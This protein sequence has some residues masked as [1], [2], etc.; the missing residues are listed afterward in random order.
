MRCGAVGALAGL[1]HDDDRD[2][3]AAAR[4][5][6]T[7]TET[8]TT[9]QRRPRAAIHDGDRAIRSRRPGVAPRRPVQR[10]AGGRRPASGAPRRQVVGQRATQS[11]AQPGGRGAADSPMTGVRRCAAIAAAAVQ[12]PAPVVVRRTSRSRAR[13]RDELGVELLVAVDHRV[14]GAGVRGAPRAR[15]R[16]RG[17]RPRAI[18]AARP[19]TSPGAASTPH[20]ASTQL[21]QRAAGEAGDR[22]CRR[23]A[24]RRRRGRTARPS[25][26][27][28]ARRAAPPTSPASVGRCEVADVV[29]AVGPGAAR[30][31][32]R[33]SARSAAGRRAAA[34]RPATRAASIA[35]CG[36]F[37]GTI[38]PDQTARA[39]AGAARATRSRSTPLGTTARVRDDVRQA[40]RCA[41][42]TAAN[43]HRR[44]AR[45]RIADSSHGVGGVC[46]VVT[47]GRVHGRRHRDRQVVQ[48]VVVDDVVGRGG[49]AARA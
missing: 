26:G 3:D 48:R 38:R 15:R 28:P 43:G 42:L 14:D 39:A 27:S 23:R 19:S 6:A 5:A 25:T 18:A 30:P 31:R 36:P 22:A 35:R 37:S 10:A 21:G 49:G 32:R 29:D 34:R 46:S 40:R 16:G 2:A 1:R 33:T 11:P 44:R 12:V 24:P 7:S 17:A 41:R 45:R 13:S 4:A 9:T 20:V 47:T 8:S